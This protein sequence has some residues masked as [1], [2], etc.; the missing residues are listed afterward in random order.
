MEQSTARYY[1]LLFRQ[2]YS[3]DAPVTELS[4]FVSDCQSTGKDPVLPLAEKDRISG[5][6]MFQDGR[7][8]LE[9]SAEDA[10]FYKML[11]AEANNITVPAGESIFQVSSRSTPKIVS[12]PNQD[13]PRIEVTVTLSANLHSGTEKDL[14]LLAAKL[15][16]GMTRLLRQGAALSLDPL[17]IGNTARK[18]YLTQT[19]WESMD[20]ENQ[21]QKSLVFTKT[22]L[23]KDKITS[24]L[25]KN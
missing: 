17:G 22:I 14:P 10:M 4:T 21:L 15:E 3:P 24:F 6:G 20:W 11:C 18:S 13:P 7:L 5:M 1:A 9:A 19:E 25:Q 16:E 8:R 12:H 23:K 2:R